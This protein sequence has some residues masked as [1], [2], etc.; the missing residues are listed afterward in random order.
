[1][2]ERAKGV[3]YCHGWKHVFEYMSQEDVL[4]EEN[5]IYHLKYTTYKTFDRIEI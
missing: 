1:M 5:N 3:A 2:K 4:V